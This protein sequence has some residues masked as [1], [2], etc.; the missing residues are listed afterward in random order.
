MIKIKTFL[1]IL[2]CRS[3]AGTLP[4]PPR[5]GWE[6]CGILS[7]LARC[8]ILE[9]ATC[10]GGSYRKLWNSARMANTHQLSAYRYSN[11]F[12]SYFKYNIKFFPSV[13]N[14]IKQ[15]KKNPPQNKKN[16]RKNKTK[17]PPIYWIFI[18]FQ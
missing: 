2:P 6:L 17:Q 13:F 5:N 10:V 1:C 11:Y 4:R 16:K 7:V 14:N 15:N 9:C 3:M 12:C 8:A 18:L